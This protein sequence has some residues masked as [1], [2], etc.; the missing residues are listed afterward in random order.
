MHGYF[1]QSLNPTV[2]ITQ[3]LHVL[4]WY[5]FNGIKADFSE[6]THVPYTTVTGLFQGLFCVKY[7]IVSYK[8]W[9]L[10]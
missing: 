5:S 3:Y 2:Y 4:M 7:C 9:K 6:D 8:L 1:F 10:S